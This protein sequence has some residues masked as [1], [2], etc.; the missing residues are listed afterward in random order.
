MP[1]PA[2]IPLVMEW[3]TVVV[4][5][6]AYALIVVTNLNDSAGSMTTALGGTDSNGITFSSPGNNYYNV[7][8]SLAIPANS[9]SAEILTA[10]TAYPEDMEIPTGT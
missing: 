10:P 9:R 2:W 6:S 4:N 1:T 5:R 7:W 8:P 3:Q